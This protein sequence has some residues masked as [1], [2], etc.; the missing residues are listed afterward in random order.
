MGGIFLKSLIFYTCIF[1]TSISF[2]ET[3]LLGV[4]D[5]F[6]ASNGSEALAIS[7]SLVQ[8]GYSGL[9]DTTTVNAQIAASFNISAYAGNITGATIKILK[10]PLNDSGGEDNDRLTILVGDQD[11]NSGYPIALGWDGGANSYFDWDWR[12]SYPH[13][14]EDGFLE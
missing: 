8:S 2:S 12:W 5:D 11:I 1:L 3:I 9:A 4:K 10:K 13:S 14:V 7:D 6:S